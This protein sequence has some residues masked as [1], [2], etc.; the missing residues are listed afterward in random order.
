MEIEDRHILVM[1]RCPKGVDHELG[2][3]HLR[4]LVVQKVLGTLEQRC[5]NVSTNEIILHP[6]GV[7][8]LLHQAVQQFNIHEIAA[9]IAKAKPSAVNSTGR[10]TATLEDFEPYAP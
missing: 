3:I 5:S 8:Y 2:C 10:K 9:A 1:L 6:S 4:S 7:S